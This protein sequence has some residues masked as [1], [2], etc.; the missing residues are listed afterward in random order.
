[1][2]KSL[3]NDSDD[4]NNNNN[5]PL[6]KIIREKKRKLDERRVRSVYL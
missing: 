2:E 6:H 4:D 3:I 5:R 1:M